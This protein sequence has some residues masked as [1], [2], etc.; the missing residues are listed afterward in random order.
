M[1]SDH[2]EQL[3]EQFSAHIS[4]QIQSSID[5]DQNELNEQNDEKSDGNLKRRTASKVF[6]VQGV[7]S[8]FVFSDCLNDVAAGPFLETQKRQ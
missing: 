7:L 3:E 8:N 4:T 6:L 1:N 5:D 2:L